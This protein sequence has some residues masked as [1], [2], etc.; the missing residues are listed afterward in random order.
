MLQ[1]HDILIPLISKNTPIMNRFKLK[2]FSEAHSVALKWVYNE[3]N[4]CSIVSLR[5]PMILNWFILNQFCTKHINMLFKK[6]P[7]MLSV[8]VY[9]DITCPRPTVGAAR[10]VQLYP[11]CTRGQRP[12]GRSCQL[13]WQ[14]TSS[15]LGPIKG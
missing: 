12:T 13:P 9:E 8:S 1:T 10:R 3:D 4:H 11:G 2:R 5:D 6:N 14:H 15:H 7:I